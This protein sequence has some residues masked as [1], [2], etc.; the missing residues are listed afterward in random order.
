MSAS[1][2]S[3]RNSATR[4]AQ[5]SLAVI[6]ASRSPSTW[7]G[8][9]TLF[10]NSSSSASL[11]TPSRISRIGGMRTP[12]SK[13]SRQSADQRLPPTSGLC[14]IDPAKPTSAPAWKIG[15]TAVMSG[16]WPVASQGSLVMTQSPGRQVSAGNFARKCL[17]V[18]GRMQEKLAMPPVFSDDAVAVAV[19]QHAGEVVGLADDGGEGGAQQGGRGLVGDGD[20]PAPEDLQRDRVEALIVSHADHPFAVAER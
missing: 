7:F 8:T 19:H 12:S 1:F 11:R 17:V 16:R 3:S 15:V 6:C 14:A 10:R 5:T 9:R 2:A 20:Q 18:F 13:T 4:A